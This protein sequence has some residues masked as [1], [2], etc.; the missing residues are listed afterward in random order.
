MRRPC[1]ALRGQESPPLVRDALLQRAQ[2]PG[3]E[4][5]LVPGD[6]T[7]GAF[8]HQIDGDELLR[9]LFRVGVRLRVSVKSEEGL[10]RPAVARAQLTE[11][12]AGLLRIVAARAK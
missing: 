9:E 4:S 11:R 10:Q 7:E 3:P 6:A 5:D 12:G 1:A 8:F 2:E